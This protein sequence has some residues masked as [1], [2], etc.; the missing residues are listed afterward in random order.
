MTM[1]ECRLYIEAELKKGRTKKQIAEYLQAN[2]REG[3]WKRQLEQ[4]PEALELKKNKKVNYFLFYTLLSLMLLKIIL[5][6]IFV[7]YQRDNSFFLSNYFSMTFLMGICILIFLR[8]GLAIAYNLILVYPI[9]T[10]LGGSLLEIVVSI[11]LAIIA[12]FLK[13]KLHPQYGWFGMKTK[14][15]KLY[16]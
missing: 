9:F 2:Y 5:G 12:Y 13:K 16:I 11:P 6:V 4:Y 15:G 1:K 7:T 10:L 8:K 3:L 14:A